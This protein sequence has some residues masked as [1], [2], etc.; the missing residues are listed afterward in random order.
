MKEDEIRPREL[1]SEYLALSRKDVAIF[2]PEQNRKQ[3]NCVGCGHPTS[4]LD[5]IKQGFATDF[6]TLVGRFSFLRD[7]LK[8]I[9]SLSMKIPSHLGIGRKFF[10]QQLQNLGEKRFSGLE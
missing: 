1:L 3:V 4:T 5:F 8:K 10:F 7:P 9:F 6:A 2:F